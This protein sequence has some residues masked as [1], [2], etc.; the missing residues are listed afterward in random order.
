MSPAEADRATTERDKA[1][2]RFVQ[3]LKQLVERQ[4]LGALAALRRGLGRPEGTTSEM[5]PYVIPHL[6]PDPWPGEGEAYF[7]IGALFAWHQLDAT[8]TQESRDT[9]FGASYRRLV[10]VVGSESIERRFIA[11]LN[12]HRDDI[13]DHLRHA[14][15]LLRSKEIRIDWTRLLRDVIRWDHPNRV[16]Q[17]AW[18]RSYWYTYSSN[19]P[20][21]LDVNGQLR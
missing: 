12:A 3:S 5:Y 6:P 20:P 4:D 14:V 16:V 21:S 9:S 19:Q 10:G 15:G 17:Q 2:W 13:P 11:L 1:P 7:L 18:A 8:P